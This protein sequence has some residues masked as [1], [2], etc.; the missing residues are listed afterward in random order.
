MKQE[1]DFVSRYQYLENLNNLAFNLAY[2]RKHKEVLLASGANLLFS[3]RA[4]TEVDP[5][6]NNR[7]VSSGDDMFL[8]H[9]FKLQNKGIVLSYDKGLWVETYA[10]KSIK[11]AIDQRIRWLSKMKKLKRDT[12]FKI[13]LAASAFHLLLLSSLL[14][15]YFFP[16]G[17]LIFLFFI[18][19]KVNVQFTLMQK[20][21]S[22]E[23]ERIGYIRTFLF[24]IVYL[25]ALPFLVF[26][27]IFRNPKWKG[28][29]IGV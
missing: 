15:S 29:K 12:S 28:R 24:E 25:F 26:L 23:G 3:K 10:Q 22:Y 19:I 21:S 5:Y 2:Y 18:L 1:D 27:S 13:G 8:L 16:Y 9:S 11:N 6:N 20:V 7:G 17:L 4:F 14:L